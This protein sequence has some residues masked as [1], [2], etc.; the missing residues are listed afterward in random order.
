MKFSGHRRWPERPPRLAEQPAGTEG[1]RLIAGLQPVRE[2]IRAHRSALKRVAIEQK[3]SPTLEA[4]AR[5][6][7]DQGVAE[8]V[9]VPRADLDRWTDGAQHQGAAAWG[10]ELALTP[11]ETLL[12]DPSLLALALDGIQDPQNFGAVIRAAV[13]VAD[14]AVIWGEHSSAPLSPATG[15]ASAG[16]L[17]L[18]RL[19]RVPSL[20]GALN[21]ARERGI[22]VIGLDAHAPQRISELPLSGP[23]VL[24][25]GNEHEGMGRAVRRACTAVGRLLASGRI[26]S[27]NA[28]VAAALALH[29]A[30][31]SRLKTNC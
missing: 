21:A 4:L 24:V 10:P 15:R 9:R 19:C 8:I 16:A 23:T 17:E 2:A 1:L 25:V 30:V 6:A 18:A 14:A 7:A 11:L 20:V 31:N 5:F 3:P 12:D 22:A 13:G 28:S 29:E 27:L 26:D